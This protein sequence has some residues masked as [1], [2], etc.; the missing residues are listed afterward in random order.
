[1]AQNINRSGAPF[2]ALL[3]NDKVDLGYWRTMAGNQSAGMNDAAVAAL[4]K[5]GFKGTL[6]DM[7]CGFYREHTGD[8]DITTAWATFIHN[9]FIRTLVSDN[10]NR[11]DNTVLGNADTGQ[12]WKLVFGAWGIATNKAQCQ[13]AA[14]I[15]AIVVD[16]GKSDFTLAADTTFTG[17]SGLCFRH[18]DL[19]NQLMVRMNASSIGLFKYVDSNSPEPI[20]TYNFTP[21]IGTTYNIKVVV[22]GSS[23]GIY[24]DGALIISANDSAHME[25]TYCGL[26]TFQNDTVTFDNFKVTQVV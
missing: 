7:L 1:M 4:R 2:G 22:R 12:P 19:T 21:L 10:F 11:A 25:K 15:S 6:G 9:D 3:V 17:Y 23:I 5:Q 24:L 26:Y 16:T 20:R 8:T 14:D 18:K 13:D